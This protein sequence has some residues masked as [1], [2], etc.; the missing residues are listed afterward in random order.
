MCV[1]WVSQRSR[2]ACLLAAAAFTNVGVNVFLYQI[3]Q[4]LDAW[5]VGKE[6]LSHDRGIGSEDSD[7][8]RAAPTDHQD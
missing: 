2:L 3:L 1:K 4:V 6:P 7:Y 8:S 5:A